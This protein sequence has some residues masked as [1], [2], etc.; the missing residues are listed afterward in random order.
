M[1]KSSNQIIFRGYGKREG[2]GWV[3]VCIDLNIAAQGA[4][5]KDA[6]NNCTELIKE[7]VEY[8]CA[9]YPE[10]VHRYIPRP[11]PQ[12]FIDEFNSIVGALIAPVKKGTARNFIIHNYNYHPSALSDC[13]V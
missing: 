13:A 11:A 1:P 6:A 3:A 8:V 2:D 4:T 7:Y 9:N 12:E 10:D 5:M